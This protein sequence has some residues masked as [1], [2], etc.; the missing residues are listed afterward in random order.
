MIKGVAKGMEL[1]AVYGL[2]VGAVLTGRVVQRGD[3]LRIIANR[4]GTSVDSLL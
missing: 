2:E 3:T 1:K 4:Y